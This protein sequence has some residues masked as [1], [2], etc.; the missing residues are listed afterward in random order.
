MCSCQQSTPKNVLKDCNVLEGKANHLHQK[1]QSALLWCWKKCGQTNTIELVHP[2]KR[3]Q[4]LY[5]QLLLVPNKL[6][7][8][9]F[10]VNSIFLVLATVE[11]MSWA[12]VNEFHSIISQTI[13]VDVCLRTTFSPRMLILPPETNYIFT[14]WSV[15]TELTSSWSAW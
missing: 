11:N 14:F 9:S 2:Q 7:C 5:L 4:V 13:H 8:F 3:W 15:C 12:R 10:Q 6:I 1:R